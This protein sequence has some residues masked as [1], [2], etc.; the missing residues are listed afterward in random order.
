[1]VTITTRT[2]LITATAT[3]VDRIDVQ[4]TQTVALVQTKYVD[5]IINV[6]VLVDSCGKC[7]ASNWTRF[8]C[9]SICKRE[10]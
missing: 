6:Y 9:C 2:T 1:M 7:S 10:R 4:P 5:T 8:C 3:T